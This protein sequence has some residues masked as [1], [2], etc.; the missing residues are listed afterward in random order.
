VIAVAL[1]S[2]FWLLK[3]G[4]KK[5]KKKKIAE[6]LWDTF[7]GCRQ[8][9]CHVAF[10]AAQHLAPGDPR[11][12][13]APSPRRMVLVRPPGDPEVQRENFPG[14]LFATVR[15]LGVATNQR[16]SL[17]KPL[18]DEISFSRFRTLRASGGRRRRLP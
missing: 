2:A 8:R 17:R 1:A 5:K 6:T 16:V 9:I 13:R 18:I 3:L 14:R 10:V 15:G 12:P 11:I 4:K 7:A